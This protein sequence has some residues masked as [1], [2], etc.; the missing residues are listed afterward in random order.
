MSFIVNL[1][2]SGIA[3]LVAWYI[4]PWVTITWFVTALIVAVVLGL[5]NATVWALLRIL[6]FPINFLTFGLVSAVIGFFMI[7]LTAQLVNGFDISNWMSGIVFAIVLW[8][9]SGIMSTTTRK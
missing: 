4:T 1:L 3:V 9:V 8:I 2:I 6:T 7:L 5:V